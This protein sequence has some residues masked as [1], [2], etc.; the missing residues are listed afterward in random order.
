MDSFSV[1]CILSAFNVLYVLNMRKSSSCNA[2]S[3]F[4]N[5]SSMLCNGEAEK[6]VKCDYWSIDLVEGMLKR[7]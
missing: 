6:D 4:L 7:R 2:A 5:Q 3:S 1:Q